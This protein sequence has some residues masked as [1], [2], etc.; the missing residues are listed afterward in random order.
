MNNKCPE[1]CEDKN[2]FHHLKIDQEVLVVKDNLEIVYGKISS[3]SFPPY[4]GAKKWVIFV[5]SISGYYLAERVHLLPDK[6]QSRISDLETAL[7]QYSGH[8]KDCLRYDGKV[9]KPCTCE[10]YRVKGGK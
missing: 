6:L 10:L 5:D 4:N 3:I 1:I 9:D 7:R 2:H 8:T